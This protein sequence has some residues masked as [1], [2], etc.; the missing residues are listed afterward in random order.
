MKTGFLLVR[1]DFDSLE[2]RHPKSET[3][4]GFFTTNKKIDE[5]LEKERKKPTYK[6]WDGEK[7][8]QFHIKEIKIF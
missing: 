5:Y 8:P 6:G 4:I 7:Y 1:I 3:P 2:N